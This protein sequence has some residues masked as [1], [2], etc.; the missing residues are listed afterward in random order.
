M[1]ELCKKCGLYLEQQKGMMAGEF[2]EY[3][4]ACGNNTTK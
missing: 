3:G 1:N 4:C 2:N